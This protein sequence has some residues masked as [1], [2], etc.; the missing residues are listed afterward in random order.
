M[1]SSKEV[2]AVSAYP[3]N[4]ELLDVADI[5]KECFNLNSGNI[6][7]LDDIEDSGKEPNLCCSSLIY[8]NATY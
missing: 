3:V 5:L 1:L 8:H 4:W 7:N 6:M 2:A